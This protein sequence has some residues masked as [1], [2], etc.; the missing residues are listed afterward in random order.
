MV[1]AAVA[2]GE[3][4]HLRV[5]VC[6]AGGLEYDTLVSGFF[7]APVEVRYARGALLDVLSAVVDEVAEIHTAQTR[8]H[9]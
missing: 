6:T 2:Q 1:R 7:G 8:S 9:A 5:V 4:R 3:M